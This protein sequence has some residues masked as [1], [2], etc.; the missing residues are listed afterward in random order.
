MSYQ[1]DSANDLN[2][3]LLQ[4]FATTASFGG[5]ARQGGASTVLRARAVLAL[6]ELA[7][8]PL[9][10][11]S[12]L[13]GQIAVV[14]RGGATFVHKAR[15][16]QEAGAIGLIVINSSDVP[17]LVESHDGDRVDD[18]HISVVCVRLSDGESLL[19]TLGFSNCLV[20]LVMGSRANAMQ[21][22]ERTPPH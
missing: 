22:S 10:N 12:M 8:R 21:I 4:I 5:T 15:R 19:Q 18:I 20:S 2:N 16:M 9:T 6:P 13:R 14:R 17:C 3:D 7:D 1:H 11:S